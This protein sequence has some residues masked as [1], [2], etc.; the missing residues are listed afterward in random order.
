MFDKKVV[1]T[2][3]EKVAEIISGVVTVGA[4]GG[5]IALFALGKISGVSMIL[6][7]VSLILY[8]AFTLCSAFPGFT[9]IAMNPEKCTEKNLRSIRRGCIA[10]KI[11]FVGLMFAMSAVDAIL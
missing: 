7:V 1:Y 2:K 6:I 9:N 10:A 11:I 3:G 4:V 5:Y 8:T